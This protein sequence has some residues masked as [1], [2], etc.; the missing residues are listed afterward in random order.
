MQ[1]LKITDRK[2][3]AEEALAKNVII[4]FIGVFT[5]ISIGI[6]IV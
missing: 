2:S 4:F 5:G 6:S 1:K 3:R